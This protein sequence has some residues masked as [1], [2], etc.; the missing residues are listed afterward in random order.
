[1]ETPKNR[2]PPAARW[3]AGLLLAAGIGY[4]AFRLRAILGTLAAGFILAYVLEPAV[5]LLERLKIPRGIGI[6]LI[7]VLVLAV[8]A[9]AFGYAVPVLVDEV[10]S[11]TKTVSLDRLTDPGAWPEGLRGFIEKHRAEITEYKLEAIAYLRANAGRLLASVGAVVARVTSSVAGLIVAL[12]NVVLVPIFAY[13]LLVDYAKVRDGVA[14]LVPL[15]YRTETFRVA[16]EI[17][18]VLRAF[19]RGQ[20]GVAT[21]LGVLYSI[22]LFALGTP[23]AIVIGMA[24]GLL[25]IVPYLGLALGIVPAIALNFLE[26][27]SW[28]RVAGV[29]GVFVVS[30]NIE[31]FFLTPR[32]LGTAI[33]LHPVVVVLAVMVGGELFGFAGILL[34]VPVTAALSVFWREGLVRYRQSRLFHEGVLPRENDARRT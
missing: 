32:L 17:D 2:V 11:F 24:A 18:R 22:G 1:M 31:G 27:Q 5:R 8:V 26:H 3:I 13:Y 10:E 15:P 33:G 7:A 23:L 28:L 12:L 16:G 4:L 30:Q 21:V 19:L 20:F 25:N 29:A 34:A 9:L 6:V 14:G